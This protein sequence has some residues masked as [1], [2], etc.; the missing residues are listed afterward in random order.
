MV[1]LA[2]NLALMQFRCPGCGIHL[3]VAL[4]LSSKMYQLIQSK[5]NE[6]G[7]SGTAVIKDDASDFALGSPKLS[8]LSS[9]IVEAGDPELEIIRPLRPSAIDLKEQVEDFRQQ[10]ETIDTV[11]EAL[12]EIDINPHHEKRDV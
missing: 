9:L 12:Q 8:Y 1:L 10:L 5:I 2:P 11:D 7:L 6:K 3:S 4:K